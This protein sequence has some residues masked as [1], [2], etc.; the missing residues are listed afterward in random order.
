M[1][2]CPEPSRG[3]HDNVILGTIAKVSRY[4]G[5]AKGVIHAFAG[6]V[7]VP[8]TLANIVEQS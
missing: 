2:A 4:Q 3:N 5:L 7:E 8:S 1:G 6:I